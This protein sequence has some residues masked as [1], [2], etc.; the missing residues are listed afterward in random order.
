M[1]R[2]IQNVKKQTFKNV[3][4][5]F[6]T[7]ILLVWIGQTAA[8]T[9]ALAAATDDACHLS[10]CQGLARHPAGSCAG[11]VCHLIK[12]ARKFAPHDTV[13]GAKELAE[14]LGAAETNTLLFASESLPGVPVFDETQPAADSRETSKLPFVQIKVAEQ[15]C[16]TV[17]SF[18]ASQNSSQ[19]NNRAGERNAALVSLAA[20]PRPPNGSEIK[21]QISATIK[22]SQ[23]ISR[24]TPARAPPISFS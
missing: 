1:L 22:F 7:A 13:C 2:A 20:K 4:R 11:G 10:C 5:I 23:V 21:F 17:C 16:Q 6:A 3:S 15:F 24:N 14:K 18:G 12:P 9:I 19:Q 8:P